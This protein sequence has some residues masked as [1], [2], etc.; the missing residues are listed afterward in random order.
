MK[1]AVYK[2]LNGG[3]IVLLLTGGLWAQSPAYQQEHDSLVSV[4]KNTSLEDTARMNA[5]VEH[6]WKMTHFNPDST[7]KLTKVLDSM[8]G[9]N[10]AYRRWHAKSLDMKGI[11][12]LTNR[13]FDQALKLLEHS[14]DIY[15]EIGATN[16]L[17]K[18]LNLIGT[19]FLQ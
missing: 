16:D 1:K 19:N 2:L 9:G 4:W 15:K 5:L 10:P 11:V 14:R 12:H 17:F 3:L 6:A 8:S 7:L 18:T 13:K